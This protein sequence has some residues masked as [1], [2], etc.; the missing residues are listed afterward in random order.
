M[1]IMRKGKLINNYLSIVLY[2]ISIVY[3][4]LIF[5]RN[6][7]FTNNLLNK[8]LLPCKV[9]SV[10]NI[11]VGGSGKTPMVEYLS[12]HFQKKGNNVGIISRGY[13]RK[14][15]E[16]LIVTDG[17]TKPDSWEK[18]GDEPYFLAHNLNNIP[19]IVSQSK[20]KAGMLLVNNFNT[21]I[22]ILDDGFQHRSLHRDLD[23]VLINSKEKYENHKLLPIGQLREPFYNINRSDLIIFTKSNLYKPNTYLINKIEKMKLSYIFSKIIYDDNMITISGEKIKTNIIN[24]ENI[25]IISALGDSKGFEKT[26]KKTGAIIKGHKKFPDHH[27]YNTKDIQKVKKSAIESNAKF[28]ITTEK[29]LVK[30]KNY[31]GEI[32]LCALKIRFIV[33]QKKELESYLNE[34]NK[35]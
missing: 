20:Y 21:E 33:E 19:I 27:S 22:I 13:K 11:S 31:N 23:I 12:R 1:L 16:T 8:K 14:S 10:G 9:I 34:I 35:K 7:L 6:Q 26:I 5:I 3:R 24:G 25:Y 4:F 30:I 29:D 2:P 15:K 28:L 18:F 17:K 32:P